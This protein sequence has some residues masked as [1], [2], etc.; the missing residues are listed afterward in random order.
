MRHLSSSGLSSGDF[1]RAFI[2][3]SLN[4]FCGLIAVART[5][6]ELLR[7][8]GHILRTQVFDFIRPGRQVPGEQ[9]ALEEIGDAQVPEDA[10][11]L[12]LAQFALELR[13]AGG[14]IIR[15]ISDGSLWKCPMISPARSFV[16]SA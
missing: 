7:V 5:K 4:E 10:A 14:G 12:G 15:P 6:L 1:H 8:L 3:A 2:L 16:N 13:G 9:V 11:G